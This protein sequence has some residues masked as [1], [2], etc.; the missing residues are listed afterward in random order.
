MTEAVTGVDIVK[1]QFDIAS[2]K[3]IEDLS[4]SQSG[5]AIEVRV[6]AEVPQVDTDGNVVFKP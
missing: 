4:F 2:G 6:N 3:S 5:Y 1:A